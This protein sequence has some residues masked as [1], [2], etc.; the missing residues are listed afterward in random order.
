MEKLIFL[1]GW[2]AQDVELSA[3]V[4][5]AEQVQHALLPSVRS[6]VVLRQ[7]LD[8]INATISQTMESYNLSTVIVA[9]HSM[10]SAG[11]PI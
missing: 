7:A 9:A 3:Y 10:S 6:A 1:V 5:L 8:Q 11:M 4:P 2:F